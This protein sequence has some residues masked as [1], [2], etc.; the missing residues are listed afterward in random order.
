VIQGATAEWKHWSDYSIPLREVKS[1]LC[2]PTS[3]Y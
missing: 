1:Q 3:I 2:T